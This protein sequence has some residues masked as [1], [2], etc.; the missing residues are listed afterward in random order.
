MHHVFKSRITCTTCQ[1]LPEG[2]L[3]EK[4]RRN[5]NEKENGKKEN[6]RRTER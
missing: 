2:I 5:I 3:R 6:K 4:K 1:H